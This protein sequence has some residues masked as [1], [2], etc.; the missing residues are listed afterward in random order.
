[1]LAAQ[2]FSNI[3][4][5]DPNGWTSLHMASAFGRSE[6]IAA[7]IRHGA[8]MTT[9]TIVLKWSPLFCAVFSDNLDTL[10]ELLRFMGLGSVFEKDVRHWSLLHLAAARASFRVMP[11]LL[12]AGL[13]PHALSRPTTAGVSS[14]V[15]GLCLTPS[16]LAED[17]GSEVY[18][19]YGELLQAAA[20]NVEM[21]DEDL[22][23]PCAERAD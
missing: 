4:A 15:A 23:W 2:S 8:S 3:N 17:G 1:M 20:I 19:Q 6:D 10:T 16:D 18:K 13:D 22:F 11:T 5:C 9:K 12:A 7:L 14:R 21:I